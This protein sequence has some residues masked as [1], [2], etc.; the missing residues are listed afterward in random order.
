MLPI[1][2][3]SQPHPQRSRSSVAETLSENA[4]RKNESAEHGENAELPDSSTPQCPE[5]DALFAALLFC[6]F[7]VLCGKFIC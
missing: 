2:A 7:R 4:E 3:S 1:S 5:T 6:E